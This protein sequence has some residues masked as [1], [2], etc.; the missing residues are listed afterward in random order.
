LRVECDNKMVVLSPGNFEKES[1]RSRLMRLV[2]VFATLRLEPD[3][4][5]NHR[6]LREKPSVAFSVTEGQGVEQKRFELSTSS[7]R[8]K[9]SPS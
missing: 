3:R 5:R 7:L 4:V 9:R 6:E 8:T 2:P 1:Q